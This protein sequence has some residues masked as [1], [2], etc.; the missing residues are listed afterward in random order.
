MIYTI[1]CRSSNFMPLSIDWDPE[2][3][4]SQKFRKYFIVVPMFLWAGEIQFK[5]GIVRIIGD[6]MEDLFAIGDR[7][8]LLDQ[9]IL[10]ELVGVVE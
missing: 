9:A 7:E 6:H 2:V 10:L 1:T 8:G 4:F 3:L 5:E